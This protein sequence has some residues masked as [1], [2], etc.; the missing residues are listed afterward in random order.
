MLPD[1]E[2]AANDMQVLPTITTITPGAWRGKLAEVKKFKLKE[3]CLFLTCLDKKQREELYGLL[4]DTGVEKIP[5]VHLRSDMSPEELDFLV[6]V[7]HTK[8]FNTHTKREYASPY[9]YGKLKKIICIE[10]VH[11][12][13]DEAEVKEFG[14]VCLD[15]S[16]LESDRLLRPELYQHV[17]EFLKKYPPK[18]SHVAAI[19]KKPFLDENRQQRYGIH[20]LTD[21]S[22][23]DYLKKYPLGFFGQITAIELENTIEEQL[24]AKEYIGTLIK[25]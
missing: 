24:A 21:L 6:R 17:I 16:H 12:P 2:G 18:C 8:I 10:N 5:F 14:G 11:Q 7:Y 23:L 13:F 20:T 4:K 1:S 15:L 22:E 19:R 3:I 9:D 25:K